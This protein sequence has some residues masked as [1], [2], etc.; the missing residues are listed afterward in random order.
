MRKILIGLCGQMLRR[1][2]NLT[3]VINE[4]GYLWQK[5]LNHKNEIKKNSPNF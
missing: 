2:E 5:L 1:E 3:W 4:P